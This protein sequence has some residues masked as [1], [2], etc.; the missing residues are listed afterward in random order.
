MV[1]GL[2]Q[3]QQRVRR[4][5]HARERQTRALASGEHANL[6]LHVV[7]VEQK[8][9]QKLA[10]LGGGPAGR[11]L[12]HLLQHGV[13]LAQGLK[14]VLR[15]VRHGHVLP[16][17]HG[18]C[19]GGLVTVDDLHE[20][21]LARA[22]GAHKRHVVATVQLQVHA[23]V[24]VV[25]LVVL[26]DALQAHDLVAGARRV[27]ELEV[28]LLG[29]LR[30]HHQL[31]AH[32]LE[33][34][35]ALL[36]LLRLRGLV[37]EAVD[38]DLHVL[39]VALLRRA[40]RAELLQVVLALVQIAGVVSRVRHEAL[41][42]ERRDVAH[43]RVH[44]RAV[45]AHQQ[46]G[47][48]IA[49][50]KRLEPLDGLQVQVVGGLVQKEKVGVPQ[51]QLRKRDAHLPAAGE[52]LR[53]LVEVLDGKSQA[54]QDL[55]RP[56]LELVAAQA[57]VAVLRRAV[58]LQQRVL[59]VALRHLGYLALH[60]LD[61]SLEALDLHGGVHDLAERALLAREVSLLL[62]V[63]DGRVARERH[64]ALVRLLQPHH[65]LEERGLARAVGPDQAPA[66][67]RVQLQRCGRVQ[68]TAA[69]R[70]RDL[71]CKCYQVLSVPP[72]GRLPEKYNPPDYTWLRHLPRTPLATLTKAPLQVGFGLSCADGSVARAAWMPRVYGTP[73][74]TAYRKCRSWAAATK[75]GTP[76]G[77]PEACGGPREIRTPNPGIMSP[78]R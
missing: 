17:L 24:H 53:R 43:A 47:A 18:A 9:A 67:P 27:R 69:K 32:L 39:D 14:L 57:L 41:V 51:Q 59:L 37:A 30:Q 31:L 1:R 25:V 72:Y 54:A 7:A 78:L 49:R 46:H 62:Q 61:A 2:V 74:G 35:D 20:R 56:R 29:G 65:D 4:H 42:L 15:V 40:L 45:V 36:H 21:G 19:R 55:L 52:L 75:K 5:E 63:A 77:G 60:L 34:L 66:L 22:V 44:E 10:L 33:L 23:V 76:A 64:G 38:E 8:R 48:V 58:A 50:Q 12:V 11:G 16:K 28:H 13:G 70:L 6:L 71:V 73:H 68:D 3:A 26:R